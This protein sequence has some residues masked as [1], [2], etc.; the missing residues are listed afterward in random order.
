VKA[1]PRKESK[2]PNFTGCPAVEVSARSVQTK[3]TGKEEE[4]IKVAH[5]YAIP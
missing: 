3:G 5:Y 4:P 1:T 2:N